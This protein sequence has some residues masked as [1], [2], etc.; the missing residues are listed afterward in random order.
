MVDPITTAVV[1]AG[2]DWFKY[3]SPFASV[4]VSSFVAWLF[5]RKKKK[6][7]YLSYLDKQFDEIL[8]ISVT[9]PHLEHAAFCDSWDR[10]KTLVNGPEATKYIQ[11]GLYTT[12]VFNHV[13]RLCEHFNY[14]EKKIL[15]YID[16]KDWLRLHKK[17]WK[18]P[19]NH[20]NEHIDGYDQKTKKII[21]RMI[22]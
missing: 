12:L 15:A 18:Q 19:L 2:T 5:F 11:Y 7:D 1:D 21:N 6:D 17:V 14:N 4:L 3:L 16:L 20:D 10:S 13:A 22:E 8:K 9:Y